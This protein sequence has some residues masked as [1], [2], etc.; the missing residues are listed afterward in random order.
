MYK[1]FYNLKRNP[2][3]ITP[4]PSFLFPTKR[5]NEA[6]AALY[7]GV[8]RH[9]GFVVMTGEVGTGK[10]LLV[11]CLLQ[12]LKGSNVAYAYVFNSR[13]SPLE[14][15]QYIAGDFG[16]QAS[17]KG[18]SDL[19]LD[20]S[21]FLI[22]RHQKK[23]TT[24]LVVDEAHHLTAEVLEEVRLL[25]NLET[26]Q[27]KLLQILLVGQPELDEKLDSVE[28][29]QLKQRVALRS[30]LE[31]LDADETKGYVQRRLQ[32][33]SA[34]SRAAEIFPTEA[35]ARVYFHSRGIPRLI[36]TICENTLI[37]TYARHMRTATPAIIDEVAADFRLDVMHPSRNERP[38]NGDNLDVQQAVKTLL[39]LHEALQ[40]L[41]SNETESPAEVA[42]GAIKQ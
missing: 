1:A 9:K 33:A 36:N 17:G 24:V 23:L 3:E 38:T 35:I 12:L 2:F 34:D 32:L 11:R 26:A 16:L 30:Q 41:K 4:D 8:R 14:F 15:L 42:P 10:T 7:Y 31:P 22:A 27:E 20:L 28:L 37:S 39:Q 25:T 21:N 6:L 40:S 18:K 19:L 5:H 13:L 29:R